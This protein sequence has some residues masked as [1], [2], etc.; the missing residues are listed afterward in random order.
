MHVFGLKFNLGNVFGLPLI[1]GTAAEYGLNV[2]LSYM[3]GREHGGPLVARTTVHGR[4]CSTGSR[5]SSA[6]AAS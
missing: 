5:P 4:R 3:E 1:I 2:V 6:S